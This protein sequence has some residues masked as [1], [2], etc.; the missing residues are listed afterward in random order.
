[1]TIVEHIKE[2]R[3]RLLLALAGILVG[4]IVGFIWYQATFTVGPW[5]IPFTDARWVPS[6]SGRWVKS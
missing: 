6:A 3:T 4:T 1:M 5:R 2:L